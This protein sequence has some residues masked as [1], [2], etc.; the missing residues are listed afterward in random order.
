MKKYLKTV[1][2]FFISNALFTCSPNV[3]Q[4]S[5][6]NTFEEANKLYNQSEYQLSI[7]KYLEIVDTGYHSS[8]LYFNLGNCYYKINQIANS[9]L[10]YER[11]LKLNPHDKTILN[12]LSM[13]QNSLIDI[14][15]ELP[16]NF[17]NKSLTKISNKF[18][19]KSWAII[20]I[21]MS[22]IFLIIFTLFIIS[23]NTSFKRAYFSI[24][25]II[26]LFL[27]ISINF[28]FTNYNK[29]YID[30]FA[31]IFSIK[32]QIKSE[33]NDLSDNLFNLHEGTKVKLVDDFG[34]DWVK[35][36]IANGDEGWIKINKIK[37]I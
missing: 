19:I 16:Q 17:L 18:S 32:T 34:D 4:D 8:E 1:Y 30:Q 36:K 26:I 2:I 11:A 13:V 37:I 28:G 12:N 35:I 31:I 14:I 23:N 22:F 29:N 9:I 24:L 27:P 5:I 7:D 33:P 25:L 21:L 3:N 6:T 10:Y 20:S 15:E